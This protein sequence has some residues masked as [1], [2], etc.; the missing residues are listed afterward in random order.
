MLHY[1]SILFHYNKHKARACTEE[2]DVSVLLFCFIWHIG[3]PV[4]ALIVTAVS[5]SH[6]EM[7][8][9]V[10]RI[11]S[12]PAAQTMCL[13]GK[14][15]KSIQFNPLLFYLLPCAV[16]SMFCSAVVGGGTL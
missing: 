12:K 11:V 1:I 4:Q 6:A 10:S 7:S 16:F 9:P 3:H 14:A 15:C 5:L 2:P 8:K 13:H